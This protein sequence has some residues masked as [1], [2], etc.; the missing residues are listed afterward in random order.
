MYRNGSIE[1]KVLRNRKL[2]LCREYR[3]PLR[4]RDL[5]C[6]TPRPG[7]PLC[8]AEMSTHLSIQ[9]FT[10]PADRTAELLEET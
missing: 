1:S 6:K 4:L 3:M 10:F 7:P 8:T 5:W 2:M 9:N